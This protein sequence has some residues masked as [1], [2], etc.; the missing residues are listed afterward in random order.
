MR[1][2]SVEEYYPPNHNSAKRNTKPFIRLKG[3]WLRAAGITPNMK[4]NVVITNNQII[5]NPIL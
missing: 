3:D 2:I 5:I 4:V 1:T